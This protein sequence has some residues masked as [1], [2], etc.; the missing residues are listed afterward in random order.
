MHVNVTQRREG[1]G[2]PIKVEMT[3]WMSKAQ[4]DMKD[5]GDL[6][7]WNDPVKLLKTTDKIWN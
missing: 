4:S 1:S 2:S 7:N 5:E 3:C 6:I